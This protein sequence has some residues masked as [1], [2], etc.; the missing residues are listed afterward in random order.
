MEEALSTDYFLDC[1]IM[2][3]Q[4]LGSMDIAVNL[5]ANQVF[6]PDTTFLVVI[7]ADAVLHFNSII[8][9]LGDTKANTDVV[10]PSNLPNN[11]QPSTSLFKS[12]C[13][14]IKKELYQKLSTGGISPLGSV[15]HTNK[16]HV[17]YVDVD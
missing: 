4:E 10:V 7:Y 2:I 12:W 16:T 15:I 1:R 14:T 17:N 6:T 8:Q 9:D 13:I 5:L 11:K 3:I